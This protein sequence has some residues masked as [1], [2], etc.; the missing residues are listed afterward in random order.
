MTV[1]AWLA[2]LWGMK[3][4]GITG[5]IG[6]GKSTVASFVKEMGAVVI[7]ADELAH[8][9]YEPG[10]KGWQS[11]VS[12]FGQGILTADGQIDRKRLGEVVFKD[13]GARIRLNEITHPLITQRVKALLDDYRRQGAGVVV[14]EAPLL[15]EAGWPSMVDEVWLTTA[16]REV[17]FRRLKAKRGLSR[18]QA[19]ARIRAQRPVSQQMRYAHRVINTDT[20]LEKLKA[21]VR[22]LWPEV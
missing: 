17:I 9:V 14:I 15:I 1:P 12:A 2:R 6:S 11:L 20:S 3:V 16:P 19:L 4:I 21:R 13:A 22:R 10:T 18:A 7:D 5:L 8:R